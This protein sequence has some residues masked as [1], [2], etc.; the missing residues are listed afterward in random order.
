[1]HDDSGE[2]A[3]YLPRPAHTGTDRQASRGPVCIARLA[4]GGRKGKRKARGGDLE[5]EKLIVP[6][7]FGEPKFASH[8][9][10]RERQQPA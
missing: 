10:R 4:M 2:R 8:L 6:P 9:A 7:T 5:E 1:M 3:T